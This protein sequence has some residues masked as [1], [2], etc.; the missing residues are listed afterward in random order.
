M[1]EALLIQQMNIIQ[2]LSLFTLMDLKDKDQIQE[3]QN[4][5]INLIN[6]LQKNQSYKIWLK[7]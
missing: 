7:Y 4:L 6:T 1:S 2:N 3:V 5:K